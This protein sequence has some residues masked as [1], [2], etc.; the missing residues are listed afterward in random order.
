MEAFDAIDQRLAQ[1]RGE[2]YTVQKA[3]PGKYLFGRRKV[4]EYGQGIARDNWF[5]VRFNDLWQ[6]K[7]LRDLWQELPDMFENVSVKCYT[8]YLL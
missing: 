5:E 7:K 1:M 6:G 8:N 2:P 4:R 3:R